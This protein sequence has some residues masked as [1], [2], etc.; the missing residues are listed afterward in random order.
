MG[1]SPDSA[2]AHRRFKSEL[3]LPFPLITDEEKRII[4]LYQARRRFGLG[5][6]RITYVIDVGGVIQAT[7]Q[8]EFAIDKH[9][10]DTLDTL[11]EFI[12]NGPE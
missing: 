7:F 12:G 3:D 9:I 1:I 5:T 4:R 2:A 8:H 11:R 10:E 6:R